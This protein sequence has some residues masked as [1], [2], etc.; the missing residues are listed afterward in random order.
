MAIS[1][2]KVFLMNKA[3]GASEY[4]KLV[5]IKE[6]PDLGGEPEMLDTTT[7]SDG[8]YTYIPGIQTMEG[9]TFTCN[10]TLEDFIALKALEEQDLDLAVWFGGTVTDGVATPTGSDGKFEFVG[11]LT[12][13]ANGGSVNEVVN[14]TVSVAPSTVIKQTA[15]VSAG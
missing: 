2:Y 5:D 8:A 9:M 13:F 12:V 3:E 1:T 7:L 6:F 11:R 10:Y 15:T 4:T 14:M